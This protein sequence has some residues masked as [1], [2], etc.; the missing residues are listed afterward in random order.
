MDFMKSISENCNISILK[1]YHYLDNYL[2]SNAQFAKILQRP[3]TMAQSLAFIED[4]IVDFWYRE[5][6]TFLSALYGICAHRHLPLAD[7][8]LQFFA[9]YLDSLIAKQN[10]VR[11]L[12]NDYRE[13][14]LVTSP[15]LTRHPT[16]HAAWKLKEELIITKTIVALLASGQAQEH[17][18]PLAKEFLRVFF[19]QKF[20]GSLAGLVA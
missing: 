9:R 14:G 3:E 15:Y 1:I 20:S 17:F 6:M 19:A 16:L 10:L 13:A 18:L 12:L 8:T 2:K 4:Q 11:V 7:P 5:R